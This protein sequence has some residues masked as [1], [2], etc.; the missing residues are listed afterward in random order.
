MKYTTHSKLTAAGLSL[1]LMTSGQAAVVLAGPATGYHSSNKDWLTNTTNDID[2]NGLGTDGFI[3]FGDFQAGNAGNNNPGNDDNE[4]IIGTNANTTLFTVSAPSYVTAAATVGAN[5]G[6][7]GQFDYEL[8]DNP[9][10]LDGTDEKPGNLLV[11]G[12]GSAIEFTVSG[13]AVNTTVRV[14][15]LGAV[16]NDDNRARFD[17]PT[18]SLTDGTNTVSVTGLPNLSDGTAAAS[19]GWVFFDIDADGT[20]GVAVPPDAAGVDPDVTGLGGVTFDSIVVPEPSTSLLAGLAG[21]SL[22]FRRRR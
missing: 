14:G 13:L 19:L 2:G 12:S 11:T 1:A 22:A 9:L 15:V 16:L 4:N 18:I 7:V 17:A 3:F 6:N 8:I 10:T 5:S 21:L 20:Y